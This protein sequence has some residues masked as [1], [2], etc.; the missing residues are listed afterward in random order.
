MA[1]SSTAPVVVTI[2][3][4]FARPRGHYGTGRNASTVRAA[5]PA[6]MTTMPDVDKL[7]RCALDALTGIVFR[8]DAQIV[9]LHAVKRYGE[10]ERAEIMVRELLDQTTTE[11]ES[12]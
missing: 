5:A 2:G 3:F 1:S 7:A 4:Y 12:S 6:R 11:G 9:D 8:D 10:P